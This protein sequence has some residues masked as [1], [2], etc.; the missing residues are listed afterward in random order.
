MKQS[1]R[2]LFLDKLKHTPV[3]SVFAN[4]PNNLQQISI[5]QNFYTSWHNLIIQ[6]HRKKIFVSL[7]N[8]GQSPN[9]LQIEN[10]LF[11]LRRFPPLF[12]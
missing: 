1:D 12:G 11:H 5:P 2:N 6:N 10:L 3:A 8:C 4:K 9:E 7:V